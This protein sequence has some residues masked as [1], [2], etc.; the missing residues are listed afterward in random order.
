MMM[1]IALS[2]SFVS[3]KKAC[4]CKEGDNI[5]SEWT[6]DEMSET[7]VN[8]ADLNRDFELMG[9]EITCK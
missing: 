1:A 7:G 5:V 9:K 4:T 3:C 6:A 8:C 2:A